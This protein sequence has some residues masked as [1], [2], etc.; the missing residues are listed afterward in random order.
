M[1]PKN[2]LFQ[3]I[4]LIFSLTAILPA[5]AFYLLIEWLYPACS[6]LPALC[7]M[8]VSVLAILIFGLALR[9]TLDKSLA[10]LRELA[11]RLAT[12]AGENSL[13]RQKE[14]IHSGD[15]ESLAEQLDGYLIE[16]HRANVDIMQQY[17]DRTVELDHANEKLTRYAGK[18]EEMVSKR[19][20][21]YRKKDLELIQ[22]SRLANLGEMSTGIAHEINQPLHIIKLIVSGLL[23]MGF[24]N[25]H[26]D[27][28]HLIEELNTINKQVV[29]VQRI[30]ELMKAFARKRDLKMEPLQIN[31]FIQDVLLLI[32]QQ[33][34]KR[35]IEID[36]RLQ[37]DLPLVRADATY[38]EQIVINL[39]INARDALDE[40]GRKSSGSAEAAFR[41]KLT[42]ESYRIDSRVVLEVSDNGVGIPVENLDKIFEPFFTTKLDRKGT[43]LGLSITYNLTRNMNGEIGVRSSPNEGTTFTISFPL[44]SNVME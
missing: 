39:L 15:P 14:L 37:P 25:N 22:S 34:T 13:T 6:L 38:L 42:L 29:R 2:K 44:A 8:G 18:L 21:E 20:V 43:G 28:A 30:V 35:Q 40:K 41:K 5:A 9:R 7:L 23:R 12:K 3:R 36:L 4:L 27:H 16:I 17:F 26:I 19:I 31:K 24:R 11:R 33:L 1:N 10:P 32:G